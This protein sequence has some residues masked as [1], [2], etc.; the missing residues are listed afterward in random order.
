MRGAPMTTAQAA[1]DFLD[2]E[3]LIR[4][5]FSRPVAP[6]PLPTREPN[7]ADYPSRQ[8]WRQAKRQWR[9]INKEPTP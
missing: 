9:K 2:E 1:A 3:R 7:R 6:P 4:K 8:A 5:L